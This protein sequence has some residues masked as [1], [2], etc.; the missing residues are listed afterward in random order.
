MC[1]CKRQDLF[2]GSDDGDSCWTDDRS[3]EAE[4]RVELS[5]AIGGWVGGGGVGGFIAPAWAH[6][7]TSMSTAESYNSL[8]Q[9]CPWLHMPAVS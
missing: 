7:V 5:W 9:R 6:G 8:E 3:G 1:E 4:E 2:A